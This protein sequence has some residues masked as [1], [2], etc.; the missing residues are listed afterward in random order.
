M[1]SL[2]QCKKPA[3]IFSV[4]MLL[5]S[6]LGVHLPWD[7]SCAEQIAPKE[8]EERA[9]IAPPFFKGD[10]FWSLTAECEIVDH[11]PIVKT[12]LPEI[13]LN[14]AVFLQMFGGTEKKRAGAAPYY[15]K[16]VAPLI[17]TGKQDRLLFANQALWTRKTSECSTTF[18]I[19]LNPQE[20]AL[21]LQSPL[22][23]SHS[24]FT[25][26]AA[27]CLG[28]SA[29]EGKITGR[30]SGWYGTLQGGKIST[31]FAVTNGTFTLSVETNA[32]NSLTSDKATQLKRSLHV[33]LKE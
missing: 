29:Q 22:P 10:Q 13:D 16:A 3:S 26:L 24:S 18:Y 30:L 11:T 31:A 12:D 27:K 23:G 17:I 32:N 25:V 9:T 20:I 7:A 15:V 5:L 33:Q 6:V 19:L 1:K 28:T 21:R 4:P 8:T 14:D 2:T